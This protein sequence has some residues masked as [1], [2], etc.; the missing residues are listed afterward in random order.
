MRRPR[1]SIK[2]ISMS[3]KASV[4]AHC[5]EIENQTSIPKY[6]GI[7]AARK[8]AFDKVVKHLS[9]DL[10]DAELAC[11]T[12]A[13]ILRQS[14]DAPDLDGVCYQLCKLI[15]SDVDTLKVS[16]ARMSACEQGRRANMFKD[17]SSIVQVN[18]LVALA[19]GIEA[20]DKFAA[21]AVEC[22]VANTLSQILSAPDPKSL[23][24]ADRSVALNA[25]GALGALGESSEK[26]LQAVLDSNGMGAVL[27]YCSPETEA[28]LLEGAVDTTCKLMSTAPDAKSAALEAGIIP[29]FAALI[30]HADD[31]VKVRA[32]LGLGM[33]LGGNEAGLVQC[34][35]VPGAVG[36]LLKLMRREDD[37]DCQQIAA[38]IFQEMA[39]CP[40]AKG[41]LEAG[42]KAAQA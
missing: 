13:L 9:G 25:L 14:D 8:E 4:D 27:M 19:A 22:G 38:S 15:S 5:A 36:T 23:T 7:M 12:L 3:D 37:A 16:P 18:A 6:R 26:G 28:R 42:I 33:V 11:T 32:L 31:E 21:D 24:A 29:R 39:R 10:K 34:A 35:G 30:G 2:N 40:A 17:H 20:S 41:A 1:R